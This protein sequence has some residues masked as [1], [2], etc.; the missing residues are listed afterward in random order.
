MDLDTRA[1][2]AA[3][4]IHRAVE[5]MEVSTDTKQPRKVERFDRYQ[6]RKNRNRKVG[7]VAVA[8]AIAILAVV[9]AMN[10]V[11]TPNTTQPG[12]NGWSTTPPASGAF[13]VDLTT[14]R[15]KPLPASITDAGNAYA[16]SPDHKLVAYDGQ[17]PG[18]FIANIDG[19]G[20]RQITHGN[21]LG[22]Q[23]SPDGSKIVYQQRPF[24]GNSLGN[25]FVYDVQTGRSTQITH[26]DQST[27]TS[28]WWVMAPSFR[29]DDSVLF[30]K[31]RGT[32]PQGW[33]LWSVTLSGG[34]PVMVRKNAGWGAMSSFGTLAYTGP[35]SATTFDGAGLYTTDGRRP[36]RRGPTIKLRW[37]P[38][39]TRIS[40]TGGVGGDVYVLNVQSGSVTRVVMG[41]RSVE[42][43]DD[44]TLIVGN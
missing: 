30:Q 8:A 12:T 5:V 27:Q 20:V 18:L 42:W 9:V 1:R 26:L 32:N 43:F 31:P 2:S 22:P 10:T 39:G 37:S 19:T 21:D 40:Y 16:V 7:A 25:L 44:H 14:N 23:W 24:D 15:Y 36:L 41:D 28:G 35:V 33:D 17:E 34:K 29:S 13:L 6:D 11:T 38:N 4:G 3:Q